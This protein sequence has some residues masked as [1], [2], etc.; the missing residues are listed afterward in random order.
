MRTELLPT[1]IPTASPLYALSSTRVIPFLTYFSQTYQAKCLRAVSYLEV[2]FILPYL[3]VFV[4]TGRVS[5]MTPFVFVQ[6]LRFRFQF[7]PMTR[8]AFAELKRRTDQVFLGGQYQGYYIQ[9]VEFIQRYGNLVPQDA[10]AQEQRSL[11]QAVQ[12]VFLVSHGGGEN[13]ITVSSG[14]RAEATVAAAA[15]FRGAGA[16]H[17]VS[18]QASAAAIPANNTLAVHAQVGVFLAHPIKNLV[19]FWSWAKES[20]PSSKMSV[21]E[22][23]SALTISNNGKWVVGGGVSGRVYMWELST[24]NMIAMY[25]AHFKPIKVVSFSA[26]DSAFVTAGDD[27]FAHVWLVARVTNAVDPGAASKSFATMTG[28]SLPITDAAFSPT[29]LFN[30]SNLFTSSLDRCI[31]VKKKM[32]VK[33]SLKVIK[34]WDSTSGVNLITVLFPRGLTSFAVDPLEMILYAGAQDGIVYSA[35]LYRTSSTSA[36][37]EDGDQVLGLSEGEMITVDDGG[38]RVFKGH[39]GPITSI[40][41]SFDSKVLMS[42]SEDGTAIV[43]DTPTHQ[44]L[45]IHHMSPA[46]AAMAAKPGNGVIPPVLNVTALLRPRQDLLAVASSGG[47]SSGGSGSNNSVGALAVWKRFPRNRAEEGAVDL[48]VSGGAQVFGTAGDLESWDDLDLSVPPFD[49]EN[50]TDYPFG[51]NP[52]MDSADEISNRFLKLQA[53]LTDE[54][55]TELDNLRA[56]VEKLTEHNR[57]LRAINDELYD[58]SSRNVVEYLRDR[59]RVKPSSDDDA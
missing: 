40:D 59:K 42:G 5:F 57:S 41:L 21:P 31:K 58:A 47:N 26:D 55:Q 54:R 52:I 39:K 1:V 38:D 24:G 3:I 37:G 50:L 34:V 33:E 36:D 30:K 8:E 6:F 35:K 48:L 46:T 28:H 22:Q 29:S 4:F 13:V 2:F 18:A 12:P 20:S 14:G 51:Y 27:A 45:R 15:M 25:D 11:N 49:A 43:W 16:V 10:A 19:L 17:G 44:Q 53:S 32:T 7:S 56:Q 23:L 9:A